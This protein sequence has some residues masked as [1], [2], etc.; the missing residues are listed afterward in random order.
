MS[1]I[2]SVESPATKIVLHQRFHTFVNGDY[3]DEGSRTFAVIK[4]QWQVI[5]TEI[6]HGVEVF[7]N[8]RGI[9]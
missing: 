2:R 4:L 6:I 1:W 7:K 5:S 8:S 3:T 9:F